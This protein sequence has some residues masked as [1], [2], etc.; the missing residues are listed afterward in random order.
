METRY[1][2][3]NDEVDQKFEVELE[4]APPGTVYSILVFFGGDSVDFAT[5]TVDDL[6][7][8]EAEFE[9]G[10]DDEEGELPALLPDGL[11]VRDITAVQILREGDVVLEGDL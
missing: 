5:L 9:T 6:G 10:D 2:V 1:R 3:E 8:A 4:D 7:N 11:D